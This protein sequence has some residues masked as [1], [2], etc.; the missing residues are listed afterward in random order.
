MSLKTPAFPPRPAFLRAPPAK[1]R[2]ELGA[3]PFSEHRAPSTSHLAK[4]ETPAQPSSDQRPSDSSPSKAST[5]AATEPLRAD[6]LRQFV[7]TA[8]RRAGSPMS[9]LL[10][11]IGVLVVWG[12]TGPIFQF[13][14]AWQLSIIT[15]A[16]VITCLMA[17]V[18]QA[19]QYRDNE[20]VQAKLD[21]LRLAISESR[22]LESRSS[23]V[24]LMSLADLD[25]MP[26]AEF[27]QLEARVQRSA[28]R[29]MPEA[30]DDQGPTQVLERSSVTRRL[31]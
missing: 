12:L 21:E 31:G 30:Y 10:A 23:D 24:S 29:R 20:A 19:T 6:P 8:A 4:V 5:R 11:V 15:C 28:A 2:A 7:A 18:L 14:N 22:T 25:S 13:S 17:F 3:L 27:R 16:S 1:S 9:L 26:E